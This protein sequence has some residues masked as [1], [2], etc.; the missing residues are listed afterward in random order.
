MCQITSAFRSVV[1]HQNPLIVRSEFN[2]SII[3][4]TLRKENA[5]RNSVFYSYFQHILQR[6][7]KYFT[8][9]AF[10]FHNLIPSSADQVIV[11]NWYQ[12]RKDGRLPQFEVLGENYI[13][14]SNSTA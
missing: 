2:S 3:R 11:G 7:C 10:K 4:N 14:K 9:S 13:R 1:Q 12:T 6:Q 8:E 5:A